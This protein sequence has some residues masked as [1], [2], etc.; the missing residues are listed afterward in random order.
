MIGG[1][2]CNT[3]KMPLVAIEPVALCHSCGHVV[4]PNQ[5]YTSQGAKFDTAAEECIKCGL[6][7]V[8]G[9]KSTICCCKQLTSFT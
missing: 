2:P 7:K 4:F 5:I 8:K 9:L 1:N 6:L 3:D